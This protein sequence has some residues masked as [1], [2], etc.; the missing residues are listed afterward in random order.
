MA[1]IEIGKEQSLVDL[2]G[3]FTSLTY[4]QKMHSIPKEKIDFDYYV[5]HC[6]ASSGRKEKRIAA[7]QGNGSFKLRINQEENYE[8]SVRNKKTLK[9]IA[10][11]RLKDL[12]SGQERPS[13]AI[14]RSTDLGNLNLDLDRKEVIVSKDRISRGYRSG[15]ALSASF[16]RYDRV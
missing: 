4:G 16:L 10:R 13:F 1:C 12:Y 8:C 6:D 2:H 15:R 5:I 11:L 7:I 3:S 14:E 9:S